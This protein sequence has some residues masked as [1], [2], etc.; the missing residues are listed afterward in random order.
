MKITR[1]P[2]PAT[3][4]FGL[5]G[6][7]FFIP[8]SMVLGYIIYWPMV[9]R[10]A[11]WSYL[12]LYGVLLTRWGKVNA[13]SIVFPL[14][15]LLV[16]AFW[17]NSNS[18]FL[19]LALGILSWIRSGI[20]FQR[21]L[22]KTLGAELFVCIGGG[23]LVAYFAPHSTLTWA[24]GIWMFFL[25]QSLYFVLVG[26]ISGEEEKLAVDPFEQARR[27]AEKILSNSVQ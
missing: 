5:I 11:I 7:L 22:F 17:G 10:L 26:E 18:A 13:I 21:P 2:M 9:F 27:Q 1:R 3:I 25:M 24:M 23:V 6:G 16:F 4:L 20:C 8:I 12:G 14:M 19:L 15:V